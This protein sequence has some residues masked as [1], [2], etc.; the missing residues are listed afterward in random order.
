MAGPARQQ[1]NE[2]RDAVKLWLRL[3]RPVSLIERELRSRFQREFAVSLSRFDALSALQRAPDG[4]L[5]GE[6]SDRLLVTN[7]NV[8]GLI[9][10]MVVDG[11]VTRDA[12]PQDR[13]SFRVQLTEA[14]QET[15]ARM[16]H[17]HADWLAELLADLPGQTVSSLGEQAETLLHCLRTERTG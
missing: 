15:F 13:R 12:L 9:S 6:L 5:M 4:L 7:G 14:G 8:T 16:A 17:A 11:L 10:R 2:P 1:A 3:Y